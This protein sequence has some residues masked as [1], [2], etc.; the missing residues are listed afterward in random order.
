MANVPASLSAAFPP[1]PDGVNPYAYWTEVIKSLLTRKPPDPTGFKVRLTVLCCVLDYLIIAA[2]AALVITVVDYRRRRKSLFLWRLVSRERGRYIVGNQQLLEPILTIIT[3]AVFLA[4]TI[5]DWQ[6]TFGHGSWVHVNPMRLATWTVLFVQLWIVSWAS[7]QSFVITSGGGNMILRWLS[8]VVAN[9]VFVGLGGVITILLV[10]SVGVGAQ[11]NR[12]SYKAY[13]QLL[14]HLYTAMPVYPM[15]VDDATVQGILGSWALFIKT[16]QKSVRLTRA[17]VIQFAVSAGLTAIINLGGIALLILV[18]RQIKSN[19]GNFVGATTHPEFQLPT[20]ISQQ[21]RD[22]SHEI[23]LA[24]SPDESSTGLAAPR[25]Q[26]LLGPP[27]GGVVLSLTPATPQVSHTED[28]TTV[29]PDDESPSGKSS[30]Q[31]TLSDSAYPPRLS[32]SSSSRDRRKKQQP[33]RADVRRLAGNEAGGIAAAQARNLQSLHRAESDLFITCASSVSTCIAFLVLSIWVLVILPHYSDQTWAGVEIGLYG[34]SWLY[35]VIH[36]ISLSAH[37]VTSWQNLPRRTPGA[38]SQ[39]ASVN[40]SANTST[41]TDEGMSF[42]QSLASALRAD[43]ETA[44]QQAQARER[45]RRGEEEPPNPSWLSPA[46][47]GVRSQGADDYV[48]EE[49]SEEGH[50]KELGSEEIRLNVIPP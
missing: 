44:R 15:Q 19:Y 49:S 45:D 39:F 38:A 46:D 41:A 40:P 3:A 30:M 31:S 23:E 20:L 27:A 11:I 47:A 24:S 25:E 13:R 26:D 32:R 4:H 10:S 12:D 33:S 21:A 35:A 36:A 9:L 2:I 42:S 28:F 50:Q 16:S 7:L 8:P 6:W 29:S 18:R 34:G 5:V 48:D 43:P 37:I 1:V 17:T 14:G 22:E